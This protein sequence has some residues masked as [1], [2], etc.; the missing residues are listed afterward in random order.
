M[1]CVCP[2]R[3]WGR[4]TT[5]LRACRCFT[6]IPPHADAT[7]SAYERVRTA[8]KHAD[9]TAAEAEPTPQAPSRQPEDTRAHAIEDDCDQ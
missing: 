8:G 5:E 6:A 7:T 4:L 3:P 9:P 2:W 1:S